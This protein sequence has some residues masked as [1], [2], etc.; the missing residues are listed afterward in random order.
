VFKV[1]SG[2]MIPALSRAMPGYGVYYSIGTHYTGHHDN[3]VKDLV[4]D[5][6]LIPYARVL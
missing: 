3:A 4:K 5:E 6:I 2:L 1:E